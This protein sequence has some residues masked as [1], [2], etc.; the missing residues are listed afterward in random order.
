MS[1]KGVGSK[2]HARVVAGRRPDSHD[3]KCVLR[4]SE[5]SCT[6]EL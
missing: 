6:P 3:T 5:V 1:L 4:V 2:L